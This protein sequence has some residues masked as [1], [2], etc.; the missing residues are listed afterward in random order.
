MDGHF[1]FLFL[2]KSQG[3]RV[4][5]ITKNVEGEETCNDYSINFDEIFILLDLIMRMNY[6]G[7]LKM[8][9]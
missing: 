7:E 1:L 3:Y 4:E 2:N 6:H 5:I 8:S 9:E